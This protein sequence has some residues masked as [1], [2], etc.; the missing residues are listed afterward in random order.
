MQVFP[1]SA[2]ARRKN[3]SRELV[4]KS[5]NAAEFGLSPLAGAVGHVVDAGGGLGGHLYRLIPIAGALPGHDPWKA[6]TLAPDATSRFRAL[7]APDV[8]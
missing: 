5:W 2:A 8:G 7:S 3:P 4:E 1:C 6:T